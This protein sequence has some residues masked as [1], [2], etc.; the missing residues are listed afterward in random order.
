MVT[1]NLFETHQ[2]LEEVNI[3]GR[4]L[5]VLRTENWR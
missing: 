4:L 1:N 2:D 5:E 3:L